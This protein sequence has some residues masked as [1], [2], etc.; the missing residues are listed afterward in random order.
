[1]GVFGLNQNQITQGQI[2]SDEYVSVS[3]N[4]IGHASL[5]LKQYLSA[6][7]RQPYLS[8][9]FDLLL[10]VCLPVSSDHFKWWNGL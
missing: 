4:G 2:R 3:V 10:S 7:S 6:M 5:I 9:P 1:M 8:F